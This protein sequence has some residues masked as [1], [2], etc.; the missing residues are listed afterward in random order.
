VR[1]RGPHSLMACVRRLSRGVCVAAGFRS[2]PVLATLL[3][4]V[5]TTEDPLTG[6]SLLLAYTRRA[7]EPSYVAPSPSH[8]RPHCVCVCVCVCGWGAVDTS[9][10]LTVCVVWLGCSGY[11]SP[12]LAAAFFA[13]ALKQLL[14]MRAYSAWITPARCA[15]RKPAALHPA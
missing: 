9:P 10:S 5:A 1:S 4:Y 6:A 14:E 11:V 13:G 12:L 2:T 7:H 8:R 15:R 3:G